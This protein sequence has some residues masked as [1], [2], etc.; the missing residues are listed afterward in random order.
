MNLGA[1]EPYGLFWN[2]LPGGRND[3]AML[4]YQGAILHELL[5]LA[6]DITLQSGAALVIR[7][8]YHRRQWRALDVLPEELFR[9]R[10]TQRLGS[11]LN[12]YVMEAGTVDEV[13]NLIGIM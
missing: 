3:G 6:D 4:K 8:C 5:Q 11:R 7:P 13:P 10:E 2:L 9:R 1:R 12:I